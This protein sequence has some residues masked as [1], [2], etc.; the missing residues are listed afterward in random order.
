MSASQIACNK[1]AFIVGVIVLTVVQLN[2]CD[3]LNSLCVRCVQSLTQR[4][5]VSAPCTPTVRRILP[6]VVKIFVH[7]FILF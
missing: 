2:V 3:Q 7:G 4:H 1:I 6:G 5:T